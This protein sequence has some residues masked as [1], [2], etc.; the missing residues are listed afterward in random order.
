MKTVK[1]VYHTG[2][3]TD[4]ILVQHNV[5]GCEDVVL[6]QNLF[7]ERRTEHY[8]TS[9]LSTVYAQQSSLTDSKL[10]C[11]MSNIM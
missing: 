5:S 2:L 1:T 6:Q 7:Y 8:N 10:Q 3:F 11:K 9:G 4:N